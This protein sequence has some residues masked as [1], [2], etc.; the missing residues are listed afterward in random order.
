M[1]H[2]GVLVARLERAGKALI[3]PRWR[4][5]GDGWEAEWVLLWACWPQPSPCF[6][7]AVDKPTFL[8]HGLS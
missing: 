7:D 8:D 4:R 2:D 3:F 6:W 5:W 1:R